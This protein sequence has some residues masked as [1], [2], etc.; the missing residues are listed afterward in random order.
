MKKA[1]YLLILALVICFGLISCGESETPSDTGRGGT[2][3]GGKPDQTTCEHTYGEWE[4]TVPPQCVLNGSQMRTCSKCGKYD[5]LSIPAV[6]HT[7]VKIEAVEPTCAT[8]GSTEGE[9]CSVCGYVSK[10]PS[11][12][13]TSSV[14]TYT[15]FTSVASEPTLSSAGSASATCDVCGKSGIVSLPPLTSEKL[16]KDNVFNVQANKYNPAYD[17]RWNVVDG[18]RSV[19]QIYVPGSDWFGEVGDQLRITLDKEYILTSLNLYLA[20]NYTKGRVIIKNASGQTTYDS[21]TN[22][23]TTAIVANGAA[24]GAEEGQKLTVFSGKNLRAYTIEIQPL[25]IKENPGYTSFKVGE[26]EMFGAAR[27]TRIPH[28]HKYREFVEDKVAATC[29]ATGIAIYSCY[30]GKTG[31]FESDRLEHDY[32]VLTSKTYA[33]CTSKG[34]TVYTCSM[35]NIATRTIPLPATGHIYNRFVKYVTAP[36]IS[37]KGE[38]TYRCIHCSLEQNKEMAALPVENIN[39]LRVAEIKNGIV[40]LRFNIYYSPVSYEVRYSTSE[41]T[42]SNFSSATK[43]EATVTN[44]NGVVSVSFPLDVGLE[45]CYYVAVRPYS[46]SNYGDVATVRAGG[47]KLIAIDY[48]NANVYHGEALASLAKLFDEQKEKGTLTPSSQLGRVFTD[49]SSMTYGTNLSPIID[50][51]YLHYVSSVYLY[52]G[53]A[54]YSVKVR[55]S[56]TPVDFMAEDSKWD[57]VYSFTSTSGW[58]TVNIGANTRYVQ[59]I[60]KDNEAPF[61][62]LTY[63]YQCGDGDEISTSIKTLPTIGELMGMCGFVATG[64]GYTPIEFVSCTSILR[65]YHNFGWT[66]KAE[67]YPNEASFFSNSWMGNF[68]KEYGDYAAAGIT[69]VPCIQWDLKGNPMSYKVDGDNLPQRFEGSLVK[70]DFYDKFNPYT[71]FTYA[72]NMFAFAAR[73]GSNNSSW[74]LE[75]AKLHTNDSAKVGLG[76]IKWLELGNEPD[77]GWNGIDNYY[78]AYQ[79]AALSSAAADG[80]CGTLV[81]TK[82]SNGYHLGAKNADPYMKLAMAGISATSNEYITAFCYWMKANREDGIVPLDAF[83]VHQYMSVQKEI[84]S[85]K[86]FYVGISPEEADIV[87]TLSN[88]VEIRNKF[89]PEKE[90]WLSEFGWDTNQ[91]YATTNSAHAYG[92]FTGQQVQAMWLTRTYLLLSSIGVDKAMMYMCEDAGVEDESVG[93]FGTSGVIGFKYDENGKLVEY[94]KESYYYLS[95]LKNTLGNYRFSAHIETYDENVMIQE[96]KMANGK[97]AYALWCKTSDGTTHEAYK[98][99]IN[100]STADLIEVEYGDIDGVVTGLRAD[101]LGYVSIDVSE[102]PVYVVVD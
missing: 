64:G 40:T 17:N 23:N 76:Y 32:S 85:G 92:D 45:K 51:E 43:V 77:G 38:G 20:G 95:T 94:K 98:L 5:F 66:Y 91:S 93:K 54:G 65:E 86:Y 62:I 11:N 84:V 36:T 100:G 2:Q 37:S 55:W 18:D 68:D 82:L 24:Y 71:Y 61:E 8:P 12:L 50:L 52:Y 14:H 15:E 29:R 49:S 89:Y 60:F 41:I 88:L 58:N 30:C 9:K 44:N 83:N 97:T 25:Q 39:Y 102:I 6:G 96:Y 47:N 99:K 87:G 34:K 16:T 1:L 73:Y 48:E 28:T 59:V 33:T 69:V 72:D 56:D 70:G 67:S 75:T 42:S 80:H 63:G 53:T 35:C 13:L 27:D 46:G 22:A 4:T 3:S 81:S 19:S 10:E 57:G 101:E 7:L 21:G 90:I 79:L 31:E 78:S 26:V 74:L